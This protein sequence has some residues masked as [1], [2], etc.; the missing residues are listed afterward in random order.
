[1]G[2]VTS[3]GR[4]ALCH[5]TIS[6]LWWGAITRHTALRKLNGKHLAR[7]LNKIQSVENSITNLLKQRYHSNKHFSKLAPHHD[8]KTHAIGTDMKRRN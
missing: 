5:D 7:Y 6:M 8:G 1:M 2:G 4:S 3:Y